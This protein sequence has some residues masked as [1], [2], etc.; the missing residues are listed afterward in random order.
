MEKPAVNRMSRR[1]FLKNSAASAAGLASGSVL[2]GCG[3]NDRVENSAAKKTAPNILFI[4]TDQHHYDTIAA[5]GNRY[6][7]TPGLDRLAK[8]GVTFTNSYCPYPLCTPSRGAMLTGRTSSE[9][10]VHINELSIR[11]DF[12]NFGQWFSQNSDYETIYA[13]KW[14]LPETYTT[15]IPGFDVINTGLIGQ[16]NYCDTSVSIACES[17][18][19]NRLKDRP[20]L[21]VVSFMQP[22]DICEWLRLNLNDQPELRYPEIESEL[23][24]LPDNFEKLPEEPDAVISIRK[25]DEPAQGG[26][27][28]LHW[29][30]YLWS[31]YRQI[32]MVDAEIERILATLEETG[33]EDDTLVI[34]TADHGEGCAHHSMVRKSIFYDESARVP[35][36][37]RYPGVIPGDVKAS[38]ICSGL[39]IYPT[40]CDYAG[41]WTPDIMRGVSLRSVFEGGPLPDREFVAGEA[42]ANN[43]QMIRSQRYKYTAYKNDTV[44]QLFDM[45]ADPGETINLAGDPSSQDVL[46]MHR[47][48]LKDWIAGL[49][50]APS[51]PEENMWVL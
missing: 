50:I 2:A 4:V 41:I 44:E 34:F 28:K 24:E 10:G 36:L 29:R 37:V 51:V 26:W 12:P 33:Q 45:E 9:A 22:H 17:Y 18:V 13:G 8:N 15:N 27:S 6:V 31:Y 1:R 21:M 42:S 46:N 30:Y 23:P 14:H 49:D 35:L 40:M 7:K 48:M 47:S 5:N 16:G 39:D 32:E 43:G 38:T 19:R 25:K 3:Q 20:F 11:P